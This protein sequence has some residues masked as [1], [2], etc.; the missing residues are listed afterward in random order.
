MEILC[1]HVEFLAAK[2]VFGF[3]VKTSVWS[4]VVESQ[5]FNKKDSM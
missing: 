5:M 1:T 3:K 4:F 2:G